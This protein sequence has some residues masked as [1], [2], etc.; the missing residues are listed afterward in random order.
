[1]CVKPLQS[2]LASPYFSS[3]VRNAA[4]TV[5]DCLKSSASTFSCSFQKE[6]PREQGR[7]GRKRAEP[8]ASSGGRNGMAGMESDGDRLRKTGGTPEGVRKRGNANLQ[9]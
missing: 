3:T 9:E 5:A 4:T 2:F 1:M 8:V 7:R 6:D